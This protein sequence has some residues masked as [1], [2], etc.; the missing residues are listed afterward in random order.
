MRSRSADNRP[1][2]GEPRPEAVDRISDAER[3]NLGLSNPHPATIAIER[4]EK[5]DARHR[6]SSD[7]HPVQSQ[8]A[9]AGPDLYLLTGREWTR[10]WTET[11]PAKCMLGAQ[12][13]HFRLKHY[14]C[15]LHGACYTGRAAWPGM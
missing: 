14:L 11:F 13:G 12:F 7:D 4:L 1:S 15:R 10:E 5:W 8:H 9:S 3:V 2:R 6:I